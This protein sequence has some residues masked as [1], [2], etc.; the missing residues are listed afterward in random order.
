M[1]DEEGERRGGGR[2]D[3]NHLEL[4]ENAANVS[5]FIQ[6]SK[7]M[8]GHS[9]CQSVYSLVYRTHLSHK[10]TVV[11]IHVYLTSY[12]KPKGIYDLFNLH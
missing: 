7:E 3:A 6:T 2:H 9:A 4:S 5:C 8:M 12:I 11:I 10:Y 1:V